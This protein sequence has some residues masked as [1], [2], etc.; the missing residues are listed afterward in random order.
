ML[1]PLLSDANVEFIQLATGG[2]DPNSWV[3]LMSLNPFKHTVHQFRFRKNHLMEG[4]SKME[5][6][7]GV[8]YYITANSFKGGTIRSNDNVFALNNLV[9]DIDCHTPLKPEGLREERL[10]N[11][12]WE[13]IHD[14]SDEYDFLLPNAIVYTGRGL[15]FWWCHESLSAQSNR[16]T[17]ESAGQ[18]LLDIVQQVLEK[19]K[20]HPD[21]AK[22]TGGLKLDAAASLSPAGVYRLPGTWNA[23]AQMNAE[24]EIIYRSRYT[25]QDLK[26]F[27]SAHKKPHQNNH[28]TG[29]KHGDCTEWAKKMLH[30]IESLRNMR[31][32]PVGNETRNNFCLVYYSMLRSAGYSEETAMEELS[33]FNQGFRKPFTRKELQS[34]LSSAIRKQYKFSSAAIKEKLDISE[35]EERVLSQKYGFG[36]PKQKKRSKK[37][38]YAKAIELFDN[39]IYTTIKDLAKATGI[40]VQTLRKVLH[41]CGRYETRLEKMDRLYKEIWILK[42]NGKTAASIADELSCGIN[43]VWRALKYMREKQAEENDQPQKT[44]EEVENSFK[45]PSSFS[46][47]KVHHEEE[48]PHN[49]GYLYVSGAPLC[50]AVTTEDL[51]YC[52]FGSFSLRE[53]THSGLLGFAAH[54]SALTPIAMPALSYFTKLS[55]K[56][57][58]SHLLPSKLFEVDPVPSS[59][60]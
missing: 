21:K 39:G 60:G 28:F 16:Y 19:N 36:T 54:F 52:S 32:S 40:H 17:W 6:K 34:T 37:E 2:I 51:P 46:R 27:N 12:A 14:A 23:S 8:N 3:F 47:V 35:E 30:V 50:P 55:K 22:S 57:F 26:D 4:L 13:L 41:E 18:H 43:T 20:R 5:Q 58:S 42:N 9:I 38:Q 31:E 24:V 10:R 44:F 53:S 7:S 11:F 45:E 56:F 15:Q 33:A 1:R 59:P 49:N 48:N 29:Y 25:L